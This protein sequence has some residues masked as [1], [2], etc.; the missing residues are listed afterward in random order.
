MLV[1]DQPRA[2]REMVRVTRP[3]GRVL[4]IAYG[5]PG[6]LEFLQVF[7][8]ALMAVA[9]AFPGLPD[10]PPPLEFQV[11]DPAVL[12]RRLTD[13]GLRQVRVERTIEQPAF[14]TGQELWDWVLYGNPIPGM[15]VADLSD[16]QRTRLVE[17]LH[18]RVRERADASGRATLANAINIGIGTK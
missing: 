7:I 14:R 12:Q 1:P 3:G 15:L 2:L 17:L 13:A 11:S 16:E 6:E 5:S 4:V 18:R 8:D 9:P 10:D